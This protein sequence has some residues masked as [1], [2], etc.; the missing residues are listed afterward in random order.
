MFSYSQRSLE[1]SYATGNRLKSTT[2]VVVSFLV[3][4]FSFGL[5]VS[6]IPFNANVERMTAESLLKEPLAW[7]TRKT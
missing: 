6:R 4:A 3:R 5:R 2:S 1:N 7:P